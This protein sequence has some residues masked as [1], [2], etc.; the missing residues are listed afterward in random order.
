MTAH[1]KKVIIRRVRNK[2]PIR[3]HGHRKRR[4]YENRN[5]S[6]THKIGLPASIIINMDNRQIPNIPVTGNMNLIH[7]IRI[8][9]G[10]ILAIK[11]NLNKNMEATKKITAVMTAPSRTAKS[12]NSEVK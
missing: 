8:R 10:N 3:T 4:P 2:C 11:N 7:P 1:R 6:N 5:K 9:V 12:Q